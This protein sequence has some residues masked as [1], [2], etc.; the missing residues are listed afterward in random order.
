MPRVRL[1]HWQPEE[2]KQRIHVLRAAGYQVDYDPVTPGVLRKA[3]TENPPAA[4]VIDL[5]RLPSHGK[6]VAVALRHR[7][8]SRFFPIVLLGGEPEKVER[9]RAALPDA[10]YAEWS[11]CKA[12]VK[13]AIAHPPE[14][15]HVPRSVMDGYSGTP[16]S[17]KL[18][19]K[20]GF[21]VAL[22]N[23]P[24]TFERTLGDVPENVTFREQ[25]HT[26]C[27]LILW[28]VRSTRD[29]EA[30]MARMSVVTPDGGIW[31]MWPKKASGVVSDLDGNFVRQTGFAH[32]LVDFKIC[33][34][35]ATWSGLKFSRRK[36]KS[37]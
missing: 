24:E 4:F 35:D 3:L 12:A 18:G 5:T 6:D 27:D 13:S 7:K 25:L 9:V 1:I 15:P 32:G 36:T 37:T 31:I 30:G 26:P 2:A 17:K 34:V 21:S 16:L 11:R 14:K 28:F 19:I 8:T 33:A 29:L 10:V 23:A 20:A 22:I